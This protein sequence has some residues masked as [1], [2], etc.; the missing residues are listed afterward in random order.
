MRSSGA[1]PDQPDQPDHVTLQGPF[2]QYV[3]NVLWMIINVFCLGLTFLQLRRLSLEVR[4]RGEAGC[5]KVRM[6][7][8]IAITHASFWSPLYLGTSTAWRSSQERRSLTDE[9][10]PGQVSSVSSVIIWSFSTAGLP[11]PRLHTFPGEPRPPPHAG[12]QVTKNNFLNVW[13]S[14]RFGRERLAKLNDFQNCHAYHEGVSGQKMAETS[15]EED[16]EK[17]DGNKHEVIL[18]KTIDDNIPT[19]LDAEILQPELR[20]SRI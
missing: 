16:Q 4:G 9:V 10:R 15:Q 11:S 2:R 20:V 17:S 12:L 14:G 5:G 8:I 18:E 1:E 6:Y 3:P 13:L 7:W 19:F